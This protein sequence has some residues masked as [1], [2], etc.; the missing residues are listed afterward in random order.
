MKLCVWLVTSGVYGEVHEA[1]MQ[2]VVGQACE[3]C[4][5]HWRSSPGTA[6]MDKHAYW[7][8][9]DGVMG[10]GLDKQVKVAGTQTP[11]LSTSL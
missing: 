1:I 7:V 5:R 10:E 6:V 11:P 2:P 4:L 8:W 3:R 9:A